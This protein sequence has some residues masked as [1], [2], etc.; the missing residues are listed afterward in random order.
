[1]SFYDPNARYR[2]RAAQRVT[3]S[4]VII[5]ILLSAVGA[6]YW[7]GGLR[8]QQY[9]YILQEE[10]KSL[11]DEQKEIQDEITALRA[12]SQT[13]NVR[14]EQLKT[15]YEELISEESPLKTLV[16]ILRDQIDK[17][18]APER[19]ETILLSARPPQNCTSPQNKRFVVVTPSYSGPGSSISVGN[20]AIVISATGKSVQS[21]SGKKE[22]WFDAGQAINVLFKTKRGNV[23]KTGVL[24]LY[25]SVIAGGKE[26]RFTVS[27]GTKSF[28]KVTYDYCD[29]P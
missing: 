25:H 8:S 6:G 18:I 20:G 14:F 5:F 22:A 26:Y 15:S 2:K 9:I 21:S 12:D 11:L 4:L 27:S 1:M 19:M 17:G 10:K 23:E 7:L 16:M 24:P 28:A 29:Y 13:A 3:S